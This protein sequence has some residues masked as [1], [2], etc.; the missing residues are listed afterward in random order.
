MVLFLGLLYILGLTTTVINF[1]LLKHWWQAALASLVVCVSLVIMHPY[2]AS[3]GIAQLQNLLHDRALI[4][5]C[6]LFQIVESFFMIVLSNKFIVK[7]LNSQKLRWAGISLLPSLALI[8]G[9]AVILI[10]LFQMISGKSFSLIASVAATCI[11][12]VLMA[13]RTIV[14][15][16]I[17]S[18]DSKIKGKIFILFLQILLAMFLPLLA[19]GIEIITIPVHYDLLFIII[20]TGGMTLVALT[21]FIVH[22]FISSK[23]GNRLCRFLIRVCT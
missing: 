10:I 11:F 15:M 6:A 18:F 13:G 20:V 2:C 21:G 8:A 1:S 23:K 4:T 19:T 14:H 5:N 9:N 16:S 3:I 12:I 17:R 7:S 22:Y